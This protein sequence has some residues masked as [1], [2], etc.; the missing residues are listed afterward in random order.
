MWLP[1]VFSLCLDPLVLLEMPGTPRKWDLT[2]GL[3]DMALYIIQLIPLT[4][5]QLKI[6]TKSHRHTCSG[7]LFFG[8]ILFIFYDAEQQSRWFMTRALIFTAWWPFAAWW[9]QPGGHLCARV[10]HVAVRRPEKYTLCLSEFIFRP[11]TLDLYQNGEKS[12]LI[13]P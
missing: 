1:T 7:W 11:I 10:L 13:S 9:R 12:T 8:E 5:T 4:R 6:H 2:A 3:I